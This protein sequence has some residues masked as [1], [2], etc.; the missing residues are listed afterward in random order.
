MAGTTGYHIETWSYLLTVLITA[1]MIFAGAIIPAKR[2]GKISPVEA[3]KFTPVN[4]QTGKKIKRIKS[5]KNITL[6]VLSRINLFRK[7]G[8]GGIIMSLSIVGML[9]IGLSF[10]FYS[11]F[12]SLSGLVKQQIASDIKLLEGYYDGKGGMIS[13]GEKP[14]FPENIVEQIINLD[15]VNKSHVFYAATYKV[16]DIETVAVVNGEVY[17]SIGFIFGVDDEIMNEYLGYSHIQENDKINLAS[18]ENPANVLSL[19]Y[20]VEDLGVSDGFS[21]GMDLNLDVYSKKYGEITLGQLDVHVLAVASRWEIPPYVHG[22][23]IL[24]TLV[25]PASSFRANN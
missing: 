13:G 21:P 3:A 10:V 11:M 17:D 22:V 5:I 14:V 15:G 1:V 16:P 12:F 23:G 2:A 4:I 9:F 8:A 19:E 18:F 6:P 25:M 7:K 20:I 24:P